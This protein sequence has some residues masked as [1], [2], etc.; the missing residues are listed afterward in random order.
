M[1]YIFKHAL[2]QDTAYESLLK[3]R[4]Q[5]LHQRI[6]HTLEELFRAL[7]EAE[8]EVMAHHFSRAGLADQ[9]CLYYERAGDR[10]AARSA[11]AE[12]VAH[13][14]AALAETHRLPAGDDRNRREL[15]LRF[16]YAP[17]IL[18]FKGTQSPEAEQVYQRAYATAETLD[19][20]H[21]LFKARWGLWFSAN[22]SRRTRMAR[23]HAEQLVA[24][25]RRS[26]DEA[27]FLEAIHCR[28][29][30]AFFR[31]DIARLLADGREGIRHYDPCRSLRLYR[32]RK[33]SRTIRQPAGS[34]RHRGTRHRARREAESS[35]QTGVCLH[36]RDDGVSNHRGPRCR[37]TIGTPNN[38]SRGQVQFAATAIDRYLYVRMV[39]RVR[40]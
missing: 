17:A 9:A 23:D 27:L 36:E 24:L 21:G 13:F 22:L 34:Q 37:L 38:R 19:D 16:K 28:W 12:A 40:R 15:A 4:R 18:I 30:T 6:A 35:I 7:A 29:S 39:Q 3:S 1:R 32:T 2:V 33:R 14:D 10:A 11:Y 8:P 25:A 5:L 31:G 20:E 26:G